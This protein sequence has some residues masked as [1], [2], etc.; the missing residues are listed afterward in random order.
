MQHDFFSQQRTNYLNY[1]SF[2]SLVSYAMASAFS[3][4]AYLRDRQGN[5]IDWWEDETKEVFV[6]KT[7]CILRQ[8]GG[9]LKQLG[10][11]MADLIS[12]KTAYGAYKEW[13]KRHM[14][15]SELPA[16][17]LTVDQLFWV[18]MAQNHC[19]KHKGRP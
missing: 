14:I 12:V 19:E 18:F 6:N 16:I 9:D 7:N 8:N 1:A 3:F 15:E 2:G 13:T 4:D 5:S 11:N 10:S 17:K